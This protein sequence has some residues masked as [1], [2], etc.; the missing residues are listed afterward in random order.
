MSVRV[1][2]VVAVTWKTVLVAAFLWYELV[3]RIFDL[4]FLFFPILTVATTMT[5]LG[6]HQLKVAHYDHRPFWQ[7]PVPFPWV[8]ALFFVTF[9]ALL[10]WVIFGHFAEFPGEHHVRRVV[11]LTTAVVAAWFMDRFVAWT[12][13]NTS[14]DQRQIEQDAREAEL[15]AR[16]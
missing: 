2:K 13:V 16:T 1:A 15:E 14:Q 5:I 11:W 10:W 4:P 7:R 6:Y 3:G 9:G 12:A 8:F